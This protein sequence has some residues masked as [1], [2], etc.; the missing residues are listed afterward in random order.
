MFTIAYKNIL[1]LTVPNLHGKCKSHD[2]QQDI[3]EQLLY[4][5]WKTNKDLLYSTQ[6][7]VQCHVAAWIGG[8]LRGGRIRVHVRLGPFTVHLKLQQHCQL[9]TSQYKIKS[10]K[11]GGKKICEPSASPSHENKMKGLKPTERRCLK[12]FI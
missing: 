3:C 2:P 9:A 12:L 8:G 11:F 4:S 10:L 7:P 5:K 1:L 6:N